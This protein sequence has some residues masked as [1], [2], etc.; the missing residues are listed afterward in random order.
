MWL[1]HFGRDAQDTQ[2]LL[3]CK[4]GL[5]YPWFTV[6]VSANGI[7]SIKVLSEDASSLNLELMNDYRGGH[8]DM[9]P[10][11]DQLHRIA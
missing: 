6:F 7:T 9:V 10:V 2:T 3:P 1:I 8:P 11:T 5:R 4:D